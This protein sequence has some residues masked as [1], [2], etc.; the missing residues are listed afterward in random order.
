ML[1]LES[2]VCPTIGPEIAGASCAKAFV[3]VIA[4]ATIVVQTQCLR[5]TSRLP[6]NLFREL[7]FVAPL[8]IRPRKPN[9]VER[10]RQKSDSANPA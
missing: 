6:Q 8:I 2:V 3:V 5:F 4:N 10:G 7:I 1:A 9:R